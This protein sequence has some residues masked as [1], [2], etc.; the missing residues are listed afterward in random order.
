MNRKMFF[1]GAFYP[2]VQEDVE[3]Y[4][5]H[6]N[7]LLRDANYS[8]ECNFTPRAIIV[9]HAGY[10]YSGFTANIAYNLVKKLTKPKRVI[11]IGPSH[12]VYLKGASIALYD[13][14]ATPFGD[15]DID[16]DYSKKLAEQFKMLIFDE[17]AHQEHSTETQMPFVKHYF[18]N[19]KVV[20]IVYGKMESDSLSMIID[21]I[22]LDSDNLVVISTDLSHFFT[23][24]KAKE[25]D[26]ICLNAIAK[27][28]VKMLDMGC[29]ACGKIGVKAIL[30]SAIKNGWNTKI[31]DY[32]TSFDA[33]GDDTRVV[34]Y[35]SCIIG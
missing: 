24:S 10:V 34:G 2:S 6:F 28:D 4:I 26:N 31:L 21:E 30:K 8:V 22:L 19:I 15:M 5:E 27:L 16:L 17:M 14:Y 33:S 35:A 9:P 18:E 23:Q 7:K 20:E 1:A 29:E 11:V 12:R 25:L 3:K 13:K 32:R